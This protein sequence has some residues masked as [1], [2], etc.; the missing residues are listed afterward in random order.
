MKKPNI[1]L[2]MTDSQGANVV[3]AYSGQATDTQHLDKMARDGVKFSN[4]YTTCPLCTP[5]R[6][7]LFTGMYSHQSG[8]WTNNLAL[9][10]NIRH[11]G[12]IFQAEGYNTAYVGKWHLDGHDYFGT[13]ECPSGWDPEFWYD[14]VNYLNELSDDEITLWR[15][16]LNTPEQIEANEI[17]SDFTWGHRITNRGLEYIS[18]HKNEDQPFLLVLSYDE[19]H[20]PFTC[21][22]KHIEKFKDFKFDLGEAAF[23]DLMDKP[24]HHRLWSKAKGAHASGGDRWFINPLYFGCNDFVDEEIG[25]VLSHIDESELANTWIVYTSDH[26]EMNGAHKLWG[27]GAAMYDEITNIPLIIKN[28]D[29]VR[30]GEII[31]R[32]VSHIDIMPTI[33]KLADIE[34]FPILVGQDLLTEKREGDF[35]GVMVEFNRYEVEHDSNGGFIPVRGWIN[36]HYKLVINLMGT[37]ELYDRTLDSGE[38]TNLI[39]HPDYIHIRNQLHDT[40]LAYM[41]HIRD[42]FRSFEWACR[43]WRPEKEREW[44]GLFRPRPAD[45]VAP[46]VRD[47]DTGLP[48]QGIKREDVQLAVEL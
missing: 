42:P 38:V 8:A 41:D 5:A 2:I 4:A 20:H 27:K 3:E 24:L 43:T 11:M 14:G 48:T 7:G 1:I 9:G 26:G 28:T 15:R 19:P 16:G 6:A 12:Q 23:D 13:G 44:M 29:G 32:P 47:Y 34:R 30:A 45:G 36:D 35:D 46:V 31:E 21:P 22:P 25:R 40:L 37:D 18:R 39:D 17:K 33:M 10:T